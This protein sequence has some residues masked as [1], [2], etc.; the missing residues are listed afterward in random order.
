VVVA[1]PGGVGKEVASAARAKAEPRWWENER[2][3]DPRMRVLRVR[4][5]RRVG[6]QGHQGSTQTRLRQGERAPSRPSVRGRVPSRGGHPTGRRR[7]RRVRL[8]QG[9]CPVVD[10]VSD[11]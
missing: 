1:K 3:G 8:A 7:V 5:G 9:R 6:W 2:Y 10:V 4:Q 11:V